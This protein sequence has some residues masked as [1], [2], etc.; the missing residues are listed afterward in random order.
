MKFKEKFKSIV[1][2]LKKVFDKFPLTITTILLYSVFT[3]IIIYTDFIEDEIFANITFFILY[4]VSGSFLVE[5]LLKKLDGKKIISYTVSAIISIIFVTLQNLDIDMKI[6]WKV[7][8][9]YVLTL[10]IVSIY[11]LFK[12]SKKDV[13]EYLLKLCVNIEQVTF[14]YVV[15][16][17]GIAIISSIFVYLIFDKIG[18]KLTLSLEILLLGFYYIPKLMYCLVDMEEEVNQFFKGLVKYVLTSLVIIAFLIIYMYIIKILVLRDMP[19]NQIFRILSALFI[20]GMPI[21]TMMQYYKDESIWYKLSLKLP[22]AFIPFIFLQIYTIGIRISENGITPFRYM[23]IALVLFEIIYILVYIL[24]KEKIGMLLLVGNSI[25]IISLI[26]PGVN[27]FKVSD[28]SQ[29]KNLKIFKESSSHTDDEKEK[30]YG[31]YEYLK[32][33]EDGKKYINNILTEDDINEI[34]SYRASGY[35]KSSI[36]YISSRL[37]NGNVL[38]EGY[39]YLYFVRASDYSRD[40]SLHYS[41]DEAFKNIE[42]KNDNYSKFLDN[43]DNDTINIDLQDEFEEYIKRYLKYGSDDMNRYFESHNEIEFGSKKIILK[44]FSISY[45]EES[46]E[47][48]SYTIQ[49]YLLEK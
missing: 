38:V 41:V 22:I 32:Y 33:S 40:N 3:A 9:C 20:I 7:L 19:K 15:L 47:I 28:M 31:A 45:D 36:K 2:I 18:Y 6:L 11:I 1:Q 27:M 24:K 16:A 13:N 8:V 49:G 25:I 34:R 14:I 48:R 10:W 4:F 46:K 39:K 23:C 26:I 43:N 29:A 42:F 17:I 35:N 5:S 21:W 12:H 30:I 37:S 44:Y